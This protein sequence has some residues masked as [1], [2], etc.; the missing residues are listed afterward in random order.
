MFYDSLA[1]PTL[2]GKWINSD[3]DSFAS[4]VALIEREKLLTFTG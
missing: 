4:F 2:N 1:H 3:G